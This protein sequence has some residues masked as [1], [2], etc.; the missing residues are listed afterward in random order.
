MKRFPI[1]RHQVIANQDHRI[2]VSVSNH[3]FAIDPGE[4]VGYALFGRDG[5]LTKSGQIYGRNEFCKI[6]EALLSRKDGTGVSHVI[7]ETFKIFPWVNQGGS[8]CPAAKVIGVI[9]YLCDK[10]DVTYNGVDPAYRRIGYAWA[11]IKRPTNHALS[12]QWDAVA[13]G[14]YWLRKNKVKPN[15]K[16]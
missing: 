9:E 5:V 7:F 1:S 13:I 16:A 11:G 12:H 14:E 10:Y 8:E 3:Y 4:T 2:F 15:D 6:L